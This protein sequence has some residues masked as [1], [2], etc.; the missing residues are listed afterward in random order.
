M[1]SL[2]QLCAIKRNFCAQ[3]DLQRCELMRTDCQ[4]LFSGE[5]CFVSLL[6]S[7]KL[8]MSFRRA[9]WVEDQTVLSCTKCR[10]EFNYSVPKH[11]CRK[12]GLIFCH[13]CTRNK[14]IVPQDELVPRPPNWLSVTL[15]NED[16]FRMPQ[17]VC[18]SCCYQLR[19]IQ[20]ELRQAVSRYVIIP[21][22]LPI[23]F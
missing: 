1:R 11:H 23:P 3:L 16:N 17:R 10:T 18:D 12:C 9:I 8:T 6:K 14:C 2:H 5:H 7:E 13:E 21:Y 22:I 19:D 15:A 20:E 4:E